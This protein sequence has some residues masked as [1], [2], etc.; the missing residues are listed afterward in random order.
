MFALATAVICPGSWMVTGNEWAVLYRAQ[1]TK[2]LIPTICL[3]WPKWWQCVQ[4]MEKGHVQLS[5]APIW[6]HCCWALITLSAG[7]RKLEYMY[8]HMDG[9]K[10]LGIVGLPASSADIRKS[11]TR[12]DFPSQSQSQLDTANMTL[13]ASC[14]I[15][16]AL[17]KVTIY[18][19]LGELSTSA[20]YL[21]WTTKL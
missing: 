16:S 12:H 15:A 8:R 11:D 1:K 20:L 18:D 13:W 3:C 4:G 21:K 14:S 10:S 2:V 6:R 7:Q 19:F 17:T 5:Y 9:V